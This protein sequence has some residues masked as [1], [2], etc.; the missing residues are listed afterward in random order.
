[1]TKPSLN[2]QN[3]SASRHAR[4]RALVEELER[5]KATLN[6]GHE[7]ELKDLPNKN[8]KICGEVK[9]EC[10]Y[11][12]DED[13]KCALTTLR[14]EFLDYA[15]CKAIEPYKKVV[16]KLIELLNEEAYA[17]KERLVEVLASAI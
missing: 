1:M 4:T 10:L 11:V 17:R 8:A 15:I 16:N 7:L 6:M 14:H 13:E 2:A 5:L 3:S 12:Y 9:G